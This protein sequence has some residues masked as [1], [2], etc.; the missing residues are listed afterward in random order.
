[1]ANSVCEVSITEEA[2]ILPPRNNDPAAGAVVD[3]SGV[4]RA[5]ENGRAIAGID[6][7]AHRSMAEL[8]IRALAE[9][10]AREFDLTRV[11]I[12]HRIGFVPAGEASIIMRVQSSHRSAAFRASQWM[13][14]ELKRIVPIWKHPVFK[15]ENVADKSPE[16]KLQ[17]ARDIPSALT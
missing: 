11:F 13:M 2:L 1:M 7:E 6:Y 9:N 14:D 12:H 3:F 5:R 4:V 8:Q 17:A 10:A 16:R 15:D